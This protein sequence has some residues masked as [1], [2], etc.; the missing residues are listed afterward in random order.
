MNKKTVNREI[1]IAYEALSNNK[2]V[3]VN[4]KIDKTFR[5]QISSFGAAVATGSI[6]SAVAFFSASDNA[7]STDRPQLMNLIY[8]ILKRDN[9]MPSA[10]RNLFDYV[11][12]GSYERKENVLNAAIAL[13]LAINLFE[14][15]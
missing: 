15:E 14:L 2:K 11:K 6:V 10:C 5:G 12:G 8:D 9:L 3:V 4:G 7:S 13:K 1:P